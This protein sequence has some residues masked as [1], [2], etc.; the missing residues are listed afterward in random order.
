MARLG[1]CG[2]GRMGLP[3]ATRLLEAGHELVVWNRTVERADSL[4]AR[5]AVLAEPPA[6]VVG[7]VDAVITMLSDADALE[8]VVYGHGGLATALAGHTLIEMSTVGP[9]AI[10][11]LAAS[12]PPEVGLLDAPVLGSIPAATDGTLKIFVGGEADLFERW[13]PVLEVMGT[14]RHLGPQGS[15]AAMKLV[16]NACLGVLMTGLGEA[17]ALA[18]GLGLAEPDV[19]DV[20]ADSPIGVTVRSKRA[21]IE[22]GHYPP[23]FTVALAAK[24]LRL[25]TDAAERLGVGLEVLPAVR[26]RLLA[27][28]DADLSNLDYSAV[29][30]AIRGRP[31]EP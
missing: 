24:D 10:G 26:D 29:I 18:D 25:V 27:A 22:S 13:R 9:D 23:N 8:Q 30:A 5:G 21:L 2:L 3:M 6:D 28:D 14:P 16:A 1:F 20:L 17:L 11:G 31:A 15:G 12:L 4:V 19:L 7:R